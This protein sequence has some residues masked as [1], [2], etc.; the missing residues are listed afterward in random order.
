MRPAKFVP[1]SPLMSLNAKFMQ[2]KKNPF[3]GKSGVYCKDCMR[4]G[5]DGNE[6][7]VA[8]RVG[9]NVYAYE[10]LREMNQQEPET[11]F[12]V[13][14]KKPP[15]YDLPK[16]SETWSYRVLTPGFAW[17]RWRLP[18][19]LYFHSKKPTVF[20]T[21][22]HYA[23]KFCPVP[24]AISIMDLSFLHFPNLFRKND[25]YKLT[26]WTKSSILKAK[27][28][29]SISE[30]TK[31][32]IIKNYQI[33]E[34]RITVTYPGYDRDRFNERTGGAEVIR[35]RKKYR[36]EGDYCIYVG[37]LQ[38]RK[39][40]R[41]LI[42]AIGTLENKSLK[43]VIV[44]KTGWMYSQIITEGR[45][46]GIENR[47]IFTGFA[48]DEDLPS[49]IKGARALVLISLYEGFG[50]P[51]VEAMAVGTPVVISNASSLPEIAGDLGIKVDPKSV[52]SIAR[53]ITEALQLNELMRKEMFVKNQKQLEKFRWEKAA[54]Q[55]LE[56]LHEIAV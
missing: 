50:I 13:Y 10:M 51:I 6:A 19:D 16:P 48:S 30:F 9:S 55:T 56:V 7:N 37:T 29:F 22:G 25:L 40:L 39:N 21:P 32:D 45:R 52:K 20:F 46:R 28:I 11:H 41:R 15:L 31:N 43:I 8:N 26:N 27:H 4:I 47:I 54:A 18:L 34:E 23:P 33:P 17:T 1:R 12:T 42:R 49:L 5:V 38:P 14:L 24:L 36:I 44:G 3:P 35:V 2:D 53:G